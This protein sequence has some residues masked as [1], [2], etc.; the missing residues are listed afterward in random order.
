MLSA[1]SGD[2]S[3]ADTPVTELQDLS[4]PDPDATPLSREPSRDPFD[5]AVDQNERTPSAFETHQDGII[6][7]LTL[8]PAQSPESSM[9]E[10]AMTDSVMTAHVDDGAR[11]LEQS[12]TPPNPKPSTSGADLI[13]PIIIFAVVKANPAQLASHLMYLRRY[14]SAICLTGEASYAIVNLTAVVEF[15]E[16]V[17]MAELGLG[18]DSDKVIR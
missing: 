6:P 13:L 4:S 8:D 18:G 9:I 14:R 16:H 15:L 10:E 12:T 11:A 1:S 7:R 5:E 3:P 17:A 2:P